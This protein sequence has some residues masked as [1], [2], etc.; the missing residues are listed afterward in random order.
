VH[1]GGSNPDDRL[2]NQFDEFKA[3]DHS[4][5]FFPLTLQGLMTGEVRGTPCAACHTS[6]GFSRYYAY[7]DTA[8]ANSPSEV[9]RIVDDTAGTLSEVPCAACHPSHEP[10]VSIRQ[11]LYYG[12]SAIDDTT[13]KAQLCIACHNVRGLQ[14]DAGSGISGTGALEIPRNPQREIFEGVKSA[15]N[16]SLRGVEFTGFA[17]GDGSHAG[18]DNISQACVGCHFMVV[19]DVDVSEFPEKATTGHTFQARLERCLSSY[20]VGG[21]HQ[22]TD[23]LM[24]DGSSF[25]YLDTTIASFDF[26]SIMYS[27]PAYDPDYPDNDYDMNGV[28]EAFQTEI[29]GML[30]NLK[31]QI[32]AQPGYS[33]EMF[34]DDQGLFNITGMASVNNTI[35]GA[36]YNYDYIVEDRSLGY[37]NPLYVIDLLNA[38]LSVLP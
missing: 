18:T 20:G 7:D 28:E 23:F 36:A 25:T 3:S 32:V 14:S 13:R 31:D 5:T 34:L 29:Q 27:G 15:A 21:C 24:A 4:L 30:Q 26:G 19:T 9:D 1:T 2:T 16:N 35:R 11:L 10:G 33:S 37:H 6:E 38:S 22:D 17:F 12:T 8:W